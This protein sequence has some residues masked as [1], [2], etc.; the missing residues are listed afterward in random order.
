MWPCGHTLHPSHR[1]LQGTVSLL[2]IGKPVWVNQRHEPSWNS[3][4]CAH[5]H[6]S[7][8]AT[9]NAEWQLYLWCCQ[10][11]T[12]SLALFNLVT[13]CSSSGTLAHHTGSGS[14]CL[15]RH[16]STSVHFGD[17]I[18]N[19]DNEW[20]K[21][22]KRLRKDNKCG[23]IIAG[24]ANQPRPKNHWNNPRFALSL[25]KSAEAAAFPCVDQECPIEGQLVKSN[26]GNISFAVLP[27]KNEWHYSKA[28]RNKF[29]PICDLNSRCIL[30]RTTCSGFVGWTK[31]S[32]KCTTTSPQKLAE[33]PTGKNPPSRRRRRRK[34][35]KWFW[36]GAPD[37]FLEAQTDQLFRS[38]VYWWRFPR[39]MH[40]LVFLGFEHGSL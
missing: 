4:T 31:S 12:A 24:W 35:E 36:C 6:S 17:L 11:A 1:S 2:Y 23:Y 27:W 30:K 33:S 18:P 13:T 14:R 9:A 28:T 26:R 10:G 32:K 7:S 39:K 16:T 34:C 25:M 29:K 19:I 21:D 3:W 8:V 38:N 15:H 5:Q 22:Q 40:F 20:V 37:G